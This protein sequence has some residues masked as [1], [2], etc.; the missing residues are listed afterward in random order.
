[1]ARRLWLTSEGPAAELQARLDKFC[2]AVAGA[3]GSVIDAQLATGQ[4]QN[5]GHRVYILVMYEAD[6]E[7]RVEAEEKAPPSVPPVGVPKTSQWP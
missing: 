3:G 5:G 4:M 2:A 6:V 1:M 7:V